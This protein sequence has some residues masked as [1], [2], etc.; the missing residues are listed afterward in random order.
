MA[1]VNKGYRFVLELSAAQAKTLA[2]WAPTLRFLY[3]WMLAQ[4]RDAYKASE[5]RMRIGYHEQASQPIPMK[6]MFP[7]L[8]DLPSQPLQQ[9]LMDLDAAFQN[10]FAGRA[11]YPAFKSKQRGDPGIRWPQGVAVN[12]RAVWLPKLGWVKARFSRKIEGTIKSAT[13][14][15]DGMH[16][17]VSILCEVELAAVV[18]PSPAVVGID[19]GVQES[20]ALSDGRLLRLPVATPTEE[21]R[22]QLLARRVSRCVPGSRRHSKAKRR[23]LV[24]RR[25]IGHRVQDTRHKLTTD[26]A[27]NHGLIVVEALALKSLTCS[28]RGTVADPGKNVAAKS[29]LN[30][31]LL[32]QGHAETVRQLGYKL[33]WLGGELRKVNP[34]YTSQ[35]CPACGHVS[36]ENRPSRAV[37]CCVQCHHTGHA[38][39]VAAHNILA[40]GLAA[41]ARGA[42][43]CRG[44]ES[45]TTL[46]VKR[47]PRRRAA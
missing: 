22:H 6:A 17:F 33:G 20:L 34:A 44:V 3:N 23:L 15:Y 37:F 27:K 45:G 2:A 25:H 24:F 47:L 5:G 16:W 18:A 39:L 8:A 38:D 1:I 9:T 30:R 19:V 7:W 29:G 28:A 31:S 12:G 13:V 36:A 42:P 40:A 10:F 11:E 43:T 26:L 35:T 14:R 32:A 21:R 46:K 4:R 41:S